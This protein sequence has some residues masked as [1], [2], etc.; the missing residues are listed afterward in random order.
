ME[1]HSSLGNQQVFLLDMVRAAYV[2]KCGKAR[3]NVTEGMAA[4]TLKCTQESYTKSLC[5]TLW[6]RM[7]LP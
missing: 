6:K 5:V 7:S 1:E 4:L 2:E 3:R